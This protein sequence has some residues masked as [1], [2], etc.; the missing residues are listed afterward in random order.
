MNDFKILVTPFLL[1]RIQGGL[2]A[3]CAVVLLIIAFAALATHFELKKQ[4]RE[5]YAEQSAVDDGKMPDS[6]AAD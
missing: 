3:I 2:I 6:D 4:R 1:S 5:E